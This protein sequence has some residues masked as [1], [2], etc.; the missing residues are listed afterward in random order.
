MRFFVVALFCAV[1]VVLA[2]GQPL[3]PL[4][5]FP[6]SP[7]PLRI[8]RAAE[9]MKPFTVAGETGAIFGQQDG[10]FEG[11]IFPV[12]ILS[13][14]HITTELADYPVPIELNPLAATIDVRPDCTTITY[15]HGAFTVKQH[16][17]VP[18]ADGATAG[19]IVLFEIASLRPMRLTFRFQ[20]D[21]S[22]MWPAPNFGRPSAEWVPQGDSGYYV[23]HT[24]NPDFSGAVAIP[25][26]TPGILPPYQEHPKT[27]P[28]EL[29]LAFDP[30]KDS[31]MFFPLLMAAGYERRITQPATGGCEC[32]RP[33][34]VCAH[35]RLLGAFLR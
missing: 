27:Y 11:W 20:P 30:S 3:H 21:M 28:L 9:P 16:M 31:E 2:Q 10:S 29:K 25:R 15:S 17:F 8:A 18:R 4:P 23:L 12:K 24:D 19:P 7:G 22:R 14:F 34:T 35:R 13:A 5:R 26:A 33:S 6:E 32:A 1:A